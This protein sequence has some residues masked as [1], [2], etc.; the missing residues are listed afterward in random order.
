MTIYKI[1]LVDETGTFWLSS[2]KG[3]LCWNEEVE[4]A[5]AFPTWD[6]AR[7]EANKVKGNDEW[8]PRVKVVE[9]K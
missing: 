8:F 4:A 5:V 6:E 3:S 2:H 9:F 1:R 7:A